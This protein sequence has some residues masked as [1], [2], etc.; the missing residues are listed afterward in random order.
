VDIYVIWPTVYAIA[1]GAL[2]RFAQAVINRAIDDAL[3][4]RVMVNKILLGIHVSE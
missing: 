1:S 3:P 4:A 2:S